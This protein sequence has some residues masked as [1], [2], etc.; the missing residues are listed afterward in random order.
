[1]LFSLYQATQNAVTS[2]YLVMYLTASHLLVKILLKA[3][4]IKTTYFEK[5]ETVYQTRVFWP[6]SEIWREN[7]SSRMQT[8]CFQPYHVHYCIN[9]WALSTVSGPLCVCV[10][11]CMCAQSC[12][13]LCNPW[14]VVYQA[15]LSMEFF[16]Q[17][18]W[19]ELLFLSPGDLP[20]PGIELT[21]LESPVFHW[22]H[23]R[24]LVQTEININSGWINEEQYKY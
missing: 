1:M 14:I 9:I 13:T 22:C 8:F 4:V 12:L 7:S 21:S 11:V 10:C 5:V 16:R 3:Y 24:R 6:N 15:L 2:N 19:S 20:N 18:Y 17:E 23:L